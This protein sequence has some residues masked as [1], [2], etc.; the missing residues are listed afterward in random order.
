MFSKS[1]DSTLQSSSLPFKGLCTPE[2][3]RMTKQSESSLGTG[4]TCISETST[5]S[6]ISRLHTSKALGQE[7]SVPLIPTSK[8]SLVNPAESRM[9]GNVDL[10]RASVSTVTFAPDVDEVVTLTE[11]VPNQVDQR[12][13]ERDT[14]LPRYRRGFGWGSKT[15]SFS[16]TIKKTESGIALPRPPAHEFE[17]QEAMR[18]ISDYPHLF[19]IVS[20]VKVNKLESM[21]VRHPNQPLV[22]SVC[23]GF[24]EG[25]WPHADTHW[26]SGYPITWDNSWAPPQSETERAFLHEQMPPLLLPSDG[27]VI[28]YSLSC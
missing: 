25:V 27:G 17:N 14:V 16:I 22:K 8:P 24:R 3:C 9:Q 13:L 10:Q 12:R 28:G 15:P 1:T 21:L 18:T 2:S 23:T 11:T 19:D 4:G 26:N 20:P 5:P 7:L 6:S